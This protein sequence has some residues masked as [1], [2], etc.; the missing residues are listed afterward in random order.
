M[1]RIFRTTVVATLALSASFAGHTQQTVPPPP[2]P[3]SPSP[4]LPVAPTPPAPPDVTLPDLLS[5]SLPEVDL[6]SLLQDLK[7]IR[8][9]L[10]G[11]D[12]Q[13]LLEDLTAS[14]FGPG[15]KNLDAFTE[16]AK[17]LGE[18]AKVLADQLRD[19]TLTF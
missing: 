18:Q 16:D 9:K 3:D 7:T 12:L 11:H 1:N 13:L 4:A 6:R 10:A 17:A 19:G 14:Q 2:P 8:P 15:Q 5:L